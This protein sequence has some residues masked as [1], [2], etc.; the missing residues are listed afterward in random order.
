MTDI[1]FQIPITNALHKA[2]EVLLKHFGKVTNIKV[3]ENLS[4]VVSE[5]DVESEKAI[6]N[7]ITKDFPDHN[8]ISEESGYNWK[9]SKFT[10]IVDPLDGTSNFVAGLPWFGILIAVM[11]DNLPV[12]AGA[13]LPVNKHLYY[14]EQGKKARLNEEII[15]VAQTK[16]LKDVLVAYSLDF[17][18]DFN[19]TLAETSI[20]AKLVRNARNVRSTNCLLDLCYTADGRMGAAINQREKIWD[21]TAPW[22]I[23]KEAGGIITDLTGN[24]LNFTLSEK[25]YAKDYPVVAANSYLHS[26]I[27]NLIREIPDK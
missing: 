27:I 23:I 10:W 17:Y 22:L 7:M 20:I 4:S 3:K 26:K 1:S 19:E 16:E 11:K 14:A 15:R 8:I 5:A 21:I 13:Y 6:I 25:D 18:P 12:A 9:G 24:E 2:G